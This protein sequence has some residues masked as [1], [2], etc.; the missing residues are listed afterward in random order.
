V[1]SYQGFK[2]LKTYKTYHPDVLLQQTVSC[3][4]ATRM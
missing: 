4:R 3:S 2:T 1:P